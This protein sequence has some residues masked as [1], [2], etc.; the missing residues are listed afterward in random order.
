MALSDAEL[1]VAAAEGNREAFAEIVDRYQRP[2]VNFF[3]RN[4]WDRDLAEDLA[5]EVFV[6]LYRATPR[7][8]EAAKFSTFLYRIAHNHWIDWCRTA[9]SR[10]RPLSLDAGGEE[11]EG[12]ESYAA[13]IPGREE[14]PDLA[15]E[16]RETLDRIRDAVGTLP[17]EQREVFVL[18][19]MQGLRYAEISDILDVP[20]GTVKSRMH[21]AVMRLRDLLA[22]ELQEEL[23]DGEIDR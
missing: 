2:I 20:V 9:G 7:Y 10:K 22:E 3:Y 4:T 15:L 19:E 13:R 14:A 5:Q 11:D 21:T 16:R 23:A 17:R 6:K 12:G 8:R 18:A 1:M